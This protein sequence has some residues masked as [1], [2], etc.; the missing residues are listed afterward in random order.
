[1]HQFGQIGRTVVP[2]NK[3]PSICSAAI[4]EA[5]PMSQS[6]IQP[7]CQGAAQ[8]GGAPSVDAQVNEHSTPGL[9][10]KHH[11]GQG[12]KEGKETVLRN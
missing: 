6:H 12:G 8:K 9:L 2:N 4:Y 3:H 5:T 7:A 10:S 11:H 1:M